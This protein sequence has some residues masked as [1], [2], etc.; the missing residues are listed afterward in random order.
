[1]SKKIVIA[2]AGIGGLCAALALAKRGFGVAVYEQSLQLGEVG[3]EKYADLLR[4]EACLLSLLR[5]TGYVDN[6]ELLRV[7]R[8]I[9]QLRQDARLVSNR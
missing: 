5:S 4:E 2:G 9:Y 7:Q 8:E 1:M 3:A 6:N